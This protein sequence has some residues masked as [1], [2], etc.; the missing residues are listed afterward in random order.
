MVVDLAGLWDEKTVERLAGA[1]E[2]MRAGRMVEL[3]DLIMVA[4][5]VD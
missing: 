2:K 1:K 5:T 3:K 4:L